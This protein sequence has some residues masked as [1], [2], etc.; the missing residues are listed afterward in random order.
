MLGHLVNNVQI[1]D[2]FPLQIHLVFKKSDK[3]SIRVDFDP[4][5]RTIEGWFKILVS[6]A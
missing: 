2:N 6:E 1:P 3:A 5:K 4:L